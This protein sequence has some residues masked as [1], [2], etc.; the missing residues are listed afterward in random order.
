[1]AQRYKASP[2]TSSILSLTKSTPSLSLSVNSLASTAN[3]FT[4]HSIAYSIQLNANEPGQTV[5]ARACTTRQP[6]NCLSV[7]S[8]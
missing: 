4:Q 3:S 1:M 5:R 7:G 8:F 2:I 6:A